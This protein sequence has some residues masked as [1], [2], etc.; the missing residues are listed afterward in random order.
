MANPTAGAAYIQQLLSSLSGKKAVADAIVNEI[1][2]KAKRIDGVP[3]IPTGEEGKNINELMSIVAEKYGPLANISF[4]TKDNAVGNTGGSLSNFDDEDKESISF[5]ERSSVIEDIDI[6]ACP[7]DTT[8]ILPNYSP[9][10]IEKVIQD[11]SVECEI[12][13]ET[14]NI[15]SDV[16]LTEA[17][18]AKCDIQ[19]P[20]PVEQLDFTDELVITPPPQVEPADALQKPPKTVVVFSGAKDL[21]DKK[22]KTATVKILKN[23]GD[24]V[25]CGEPILEVGG[26]VLTSPV[27]EGVIKKIYVKSTT[28]KGDN[29]IMIEEPSPDETVTKVFAES[30]I[31]K[32]KIAELSDLKDKIGKLEPEVYVRKIISGIYVGQYMGVSK[33]TGIF[34]ELAKQKDKLFETYNKNKSFLDKITKEGAVIV[35]DKLSDKVKKQATDLITQQVKIANQILDINAQLQS[36]AEGKGGVYVKEEDTAALARVDVSDIKTKEGDAKKYVFIN[37][38]KIEKESYK[39]IEEILSELRDIIQPFTNNILCGGDYLS[40][41]DQKIDPPFGY[42]VN[43]Q[44]I[45]REVNTNSVFTYSSLRI[46]PNKVGTYIFNVD[47]GIRIWEGS[48]PDTENGVL[49]KALS[50]SESIKP[51]SDAGNVEKEIEDLKS[52]DRNL[53]ETVRILSEDVYQQVVEYS[54]NLGYHALRLPIESRNKIET[55]RISTVNAYD[56]LQ[57]KYDDLLSKIK[58]LESYI[59][60]FPARLDMIVKSGCVLPEGSSPTSSF[61]NGDKVTLIK[62]PVKNEIDVTEPPEDINYAGNPRPNSPPVTSLKYWKKYCNNATIVNLLPLYWPIGIVIPTPT[63]LIKIPLPIIW[64]PIAVIPNPICLIVIGIAICGLCPAPFVYIVNPGW[65]FSI[66]MVGSKESWHTTGIRGSVIVDGITTSEPLG[67]IP[68]IT[69]PLKYTIEGVEKTQPVTVDA[70]PFVTALLPF[71]QDDLPSYERLSLSNL[72]YVLYLGKWCAAGK[73]TMGFFES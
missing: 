32:Q 68:K 31:L 70:A 16:S 18:D 43:S 10:E 58:E 39:P 11:V 33:Y 56:T 61:I 50:L 37:F 28:K 25:N 5:T 38:E 65:P 19:L 6:T 69:I 4:T 1:K 9:E 26:K 35:N 23:E 13:K 71:I 7:A 22:T 47:T 42:G 73:K 54:K 57:K 24:S 40:L 12:R 53:P 36:L 59:D 55:L 60:S 72:A 48:L 67:A 20:Q 34:S 30:E 64:K 2:Q 21:L 63:T 51:E 14:P 15:L 44:K 17:I 62:W 29:L 27:K 45:D 46:N 41:W 49:L 52:K 66:K 8:T 3:F